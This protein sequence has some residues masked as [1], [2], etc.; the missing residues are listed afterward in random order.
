MTLL[1][2]CKYFDSFLHI[3]DFPSDPSDNGLQVQ[4]RDPAGKQIKKVAFAVDA[5]QESID[6]A[7]A[8]NADVL[9]VHHGLFWGQCQT[10]TGS[11]YKRIATF[12]NNDLALIG[13]HIPL[14]AN[15]PYGNNYGL[16]ARLELTELEDFGAWRGMNIGV[17]GE[18]PTELTINQIA[19]KLLRP[20]KLPPVVIPAGK[21]KIK[22]VAIVSGGGSDDVM[23][24]IS[25]NVDLFIT[26]EFAHEHFHF[27]KE[28]GI[29]VIGGGHYETET[30][31][32]SLVMKKLQ[33]DHPQ[34]ECI[35][36]D[37]PTGL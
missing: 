3:D 24:A 31:G 29:N 1:E 6:K 25:Q 26:G 14:D 21:E 36:I 10:I 19:Q 28:A 4:N 32:V 9:F 17:K 20:G 7:I 11:F 37:E 30:V 16:A 34:I 22:T 18:L 5:C 2:L 27:A 8:E 13:Y 33:A 23:D 35:F 12:I 15:N